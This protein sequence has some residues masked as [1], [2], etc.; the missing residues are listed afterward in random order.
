MDFELVPK[1]RRV[2]FLGRLTEKKHP[3]LLAKI[4]NA[5]PSFHLVFAGAED[6]WTYD[7]LSNLIGPEELKK[8]S[9][10][11]NVNE[12][13][14]WWLFRNCGIFALPSENE[15]FGISAVE[16]YLSGIISILSTN[17]YSTEYF[18]DEENHIFCENLEQDEWQNALLLAFEIAKNSKSSFDDIYNH[19]VKKFSWNIFVSQLF[20]NLGIE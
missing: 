4:V 18:T 7:K 12:T 16:A 8:V 20:L 9:F 5:M 17:V 15:N 1:N 3:E 10:L 2:L 6:D 11:G 14:K 13:T 19:R